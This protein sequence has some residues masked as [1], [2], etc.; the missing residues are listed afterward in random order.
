MKVLILFLLVILVVINGYLV[1]SFVFFWVLFYLIDVINNFSIW[2][3]VLSF[4]E[5]FEILRFMIGLLL[6]LMVFLVVMKICIVWFFM[7]LLLFIFVVI[8]IFI[9]KD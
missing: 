5:L 4:F 2:K 3:E 6:I 9:L 8:N 1:L 7:V